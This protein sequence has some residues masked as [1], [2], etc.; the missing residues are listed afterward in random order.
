M[1]SARTLFDL[2]DHLAEATFG[3]DRSLHLP[4]TDPEPSETIGLPRPSCSRLRNS[5]PLL[6]QVNDSRTGLA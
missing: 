2:L 4:D 1:R 5:T 3:R 6:A